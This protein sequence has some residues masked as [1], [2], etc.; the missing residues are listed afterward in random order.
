MRLLQSQLYIRSSSRNSRIGSRL[1]DD[2][3]VIF[4]AGDICHSRG[5]RH[6]DHAVKVKE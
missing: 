2:A 5:V 3:I 4:L 1:G 6:D